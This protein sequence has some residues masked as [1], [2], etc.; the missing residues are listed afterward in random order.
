[1]LAGHKKL[2][3]QLSELEKKY[4]HQFKIVFETIDHLMEP[5][6]SPDEKP[7]FTKVKGFEP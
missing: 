7:H 3:R 5:D 6:I 1:M 2:A 4:D